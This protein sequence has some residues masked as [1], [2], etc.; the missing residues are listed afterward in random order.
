MKIKNKDRLITRM[1][2]ACEL[3]GIVAF[4]GITGY[5]YNQYT[6]MLDNQ[7]SV[8]EQKHGVLD[9]FKKTEDFILVQDYNMSI[10]SNR[11]KLNQISNDE[12][13]KQVKYLNSY[14]F[15]EQVALSNMVDYNESELET[16]TSYAKELKSNA[17]NFAIPIVL[18]GCVP[19]VL[20]VDAIRRIKQERDEKI[21]EAKKQA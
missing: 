11:L 5:N 12:Y 18:G 4:A 2:V 15:A 16:L 9:D 21:E 17:V 7:S 6:E 1:V 3:A 13:K 10:V 20:S 19:I 14:E 8:V